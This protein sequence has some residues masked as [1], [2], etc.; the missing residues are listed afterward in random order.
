MAGHLKRLAFIRRARALGFGIDEVRA[1]L[2]RADHRRRA[3]AQAR[4]I[5]AA[6]LDDVRAKLADLKAIERVLRQTVARCATG[7]GSHCP[8][9]EALSREGSAERRGVRERRQRA[10]APPGGPA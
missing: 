5:A 9:I 1:L 3:C 2:N 7:G 4:V 10:A 8:L 6:R